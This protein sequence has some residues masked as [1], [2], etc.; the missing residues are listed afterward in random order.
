MLVANFTRF[1]RQSPELFRLVPGRLRGYAVFFRNPGDLG[2][3]TLFMT[4]PAASVPAVP[5]ARCPEPDY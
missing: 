4:S 5:H 1:L 2:M 3:V